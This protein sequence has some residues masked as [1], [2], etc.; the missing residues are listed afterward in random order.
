MGSQNGLFYE[1]QDGRGLRWELKS[2]L[3]VKMVKYSDDRLYARLRL[4][5]NGLRFNN[6]FRNDLDPL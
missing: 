4:G 2:K 5:R 3:L 6:P 1:K